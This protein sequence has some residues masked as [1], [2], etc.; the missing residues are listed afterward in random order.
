[1]RAHE[2]G[3][4]LLFTSCVQLGCSSDSDTGAGGASSTT[5]SSTS[6]G[7]GGEGGDPTPAESCVVPGGMGNVEGVGEYCSPLGGQCEDNKTAQLCLA[8]VGQDQWFCSKIGCDA[9]TDCGDGAGCH[10][11]QGQGSACIPCACDDTALGCSGAGGGG[12]G[13]AGGSSAGG[14]GAGGS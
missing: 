6:T 11:E 7:A 1:M 2:L 12:T 4:L 3:T 10:I 13:G 9:T 14:G 8:D 5:S